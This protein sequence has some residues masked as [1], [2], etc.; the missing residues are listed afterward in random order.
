MCT[1][2]RELICG[3]ADIL[4]VGIEGRIAPFFFINRIYLVSAPWY[5]F[6]TVLLVKLRGLLALALVGIMLALK[7]RVWPGKEPLFVAV[8][9]GGLMLAML[10][11]GNSSYAGIRH[12]LFVMPPLAVLG[13]AALA[14]ALERKSRKL[15][16]AVALATF[17]AMA[18]AVPVIRPW[19]YY[20]E[21]VGGKD[22]AWH[23]FS[24][25]GL[26]S[27]QRAKEIAAYY[28][29]HMKPKGEIPYIAYS[30][31]Y[32]EDDWRGVPS[33]QRVWKD[34][35]AADTSDVITGTFMIG[36]GSLAPSPYA[37][38]GPLR[39]AH[40]VERF[41]NLLIFR[42]T[43]PLP[44]PRANRF[45]ERAL[46]AEYSNQPDLAKA[47][48]LLTK[49][50]ELSPKVYYRWIELGNMLIQC[51]ARDEAIRAYENAENYA[52]AG[53]EMIAPIKSQIQRVSREDLKFVLPLRNPVLE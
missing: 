16:A 17:G 36:A 53:D 32:S 24:D 13:A 34:N 18:S 44:G 21:I 50:L 4:H 29:Q 48:Q 42:G 28:H 45:A 43:F 12:A 35:P 31:S 40:P 14:I 30:E 15:V 39:D 11:R 46:D 26:D 1:C 49:S 23:F 25:E 37:D 33:L 7:N 6:P 47:E 51:G 8:C 10:M 19:E 27:G 41:G 3:L 20:N 2:F 22:N 9:F 38:Y 52:P 5:F